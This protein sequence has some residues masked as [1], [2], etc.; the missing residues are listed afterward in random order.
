MSR[1]ILF[2]IAVVTL[3]GS[4]AVPAM[5]ISWYTIDGGGT[6]SAGGDFLVRGTIGQPDT[7]TLTGGGYVLAG[8]FWAAR[9][10]PPVLGDCDHDVDVD[11]DDYAC[12]SACVL[13]PGHGLSSDCLPFDADDDGDVDLI[14]YARFAAQFNGPH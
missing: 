2:I 1:F 4:A 11:L 5:E 10:E 8:G 6:T 3:A 12:F 13:G 7:G 9:A 14:D